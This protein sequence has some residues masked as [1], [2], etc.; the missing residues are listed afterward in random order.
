MKISNEI[1]KYRPP[2]ETACEALGLV[3][4]R[5]HQ[6][7]IYQCRGSSGAR[8][9][10]YTRNVQTVSTRMLLLVHLMWAVGRK[11]A[12]ANRARAMLVAWLGRVMPAAAMAA[13][14]FGGIFKHACDFC[15]AAGP[16]GL[17]SHLASMQHLLNPPAACD[18][19]ASRR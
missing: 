15:D 7:S 2:R 5:E 6:P 10:D 19:M 9:G 3:V 18:R 4:S 11:R 12:V 16:C 1:Q 17:C 14:D 13:L 8:S